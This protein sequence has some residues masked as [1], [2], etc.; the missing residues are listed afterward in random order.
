VAANSKARKGE[1]QYASGVIRAPRIKLLATTA[2]TLVP[3]QGVGTFIEFVSGA[4]ILDAGSEVLAETADN[5]AVCYTNESG[6]QL[7][8][9]IEMTGFIDQSVDT[10]TFIQVNET[11]SIFTRSDASNAPMVLANLNDDFTG[12]ASNDANLYWKVAY[13]V[14]NFS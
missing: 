2:E 1:L 5:L 7:S 9:T 6:E 13:R 12:N 10:V 11:P 8:D 14:H 4:L 3:G